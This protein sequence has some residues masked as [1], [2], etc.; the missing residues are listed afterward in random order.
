VKG[1]PIQFPQCTSEG[2]LVTISGDGISV[3]LHFGALINVSLPANGIRSI[4]GSFGDYWGR[5]VYIEKDKYISLYAWVSIASDHPTGADSIQ[6]EVHGESKWRP[7]LR[8][9]KTFARSLYFWDVYASSFE[10]ARSPRHDEIDTLETFQRQNTAEQA[11]EDDWVRSLHDARNLLARVVAACEVPFGYVIAKAE[12]ELLLARTKEHLVGMS[13]NLLSI[14]T[15]YVLEK[16]SVQ[17]VY[18]SKAYVKSGSRRSPHPCSCG[19]LAVEAMD[20]ELATEANQRRSVYSCLGCGAVGEDDGRQ[21]LIRNLSPREVEKGRSLQMNF[22]CSAPEDENLLVLGV[23]II[24]CW[25][26]SRTMSG[27]LKAQDILANQNTSV[28]LEVSVPDDL[29][30]GLYSVA[31]L[32]VVNGEPAIF[33]SM[34]D[35]HG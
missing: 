24:E 7:D 28:C 31:A 15:D 2:D 11:Q 25:R 35:V 34:I 30:S 5:G 27:H 10:I 22:K 6:F 4:S 19:S 12:T 23:L 29:P 17:F 26:R 14:V 32:F 33:R 9:A 21:L 20:F 13:L 3:D 1:I 16:G 18:W 8:Q